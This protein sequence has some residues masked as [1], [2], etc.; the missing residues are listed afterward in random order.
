MTPSGIEPKTFRFV[1]QYLNHC[2]IAVPKA[3]RM[4][5]KLFKSA[6]NTHADA[7]SRVSSLVMDKGV[8]EEKRQ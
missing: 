1:A 4:T 2:A 7:L 6:S 3:G 8:T 5:K